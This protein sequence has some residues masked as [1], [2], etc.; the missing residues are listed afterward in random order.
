[1]QKPVFVFNDNGEADWAE[2]GLTQSGPYTKRPSIE[3]IPRSV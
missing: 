3:T 1:M 2:K